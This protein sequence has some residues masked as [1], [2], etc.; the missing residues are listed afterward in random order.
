MKL[1]NGVTVFDD[2]PEMYYNIFTEIGLKINK[3]HYL[4]DVDTGIVLRYKDKFIKATNKPYEILYAGKTDILFEPMSN[5]N[6]M[7]SIFGYYIDKEYSDIPGFFKAQYVEDDEAR[8]K[9]RVVIKTITGDIGSPFYNNV[10]LGYCYCI[11]TLAG[12]NVNLDNFD[13]VI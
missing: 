7:V 10:Y 1:Y 8:E 9:Q 13:L 11:L 3:D 12:Y 4:E 5:Y 2:V 6:L